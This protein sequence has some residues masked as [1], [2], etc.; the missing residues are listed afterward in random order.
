M[1]KKVKWSAGTTDLKLD[2]T[3]DDYADDILAALTNAIE[4]G[5]MSIGMSA[6]EYAQKAVPVDTGR[7]RNSITFA[8]KGHEGYAHT[9]KDD[10]NK[11]YSYQVGAGA[12]EDAVYIGS[13]VEYAASVELGN[14]R[15]MRPRPYLRPAAT[16]HTE[17]YKDIIRDSLENA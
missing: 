6:V 4:R 11:M 3:L 2:L 14:S 12:E 15:G 9:Y 7:L 8:C 13:N 17:E 10:N 5:L 1:S 16:E